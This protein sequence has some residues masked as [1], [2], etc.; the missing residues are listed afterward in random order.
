MFSRAC[1]YKKF[2]QSSEIR[3][4]LGDTFVTNQFMLSSEL[5]QKTSAWSDMSVPQLL[6]QNRIVPIL[7]R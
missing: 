7:E 4:L 6:L 1:N 5:Q 3:K 2:I